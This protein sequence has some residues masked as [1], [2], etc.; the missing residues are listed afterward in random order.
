MSYSTGSATTVVNMMSAF[1]SFAVA[2]A[3]MTLSINRT[4]QVPSASVDPLDAYTV[5]CLSK[6]GQHWWF[7]YRS[8]KVFGFPC[9]SNAGADWAN[10]TNRPLNDSELTPIFE[11]FTSYHL[12]S[13]GSMVHAALEM[14]NGSWTHMNIFSL[15]KYGSFTGGHGLGVTNCLTD[16]S[17]GPDISGT[18]HNYMFGTPAMNDGGGLFMSR[19]Y[20]PYNGK[21]YANIGVPISHSSTDYNGALFAHHVNGVGDRIL[22]DCPN[23]FNGRTFGVRMEAF[24][25]DNAPG[26]SGLWLPLGYIPNIRAINIKDLNPKDVINTDWLAFPC[27]A[28]NAFLL[29]TYANSVNRGWAVRK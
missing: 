29:N 3:G 13:E 11:P 24:L 18:Y 16:S 6:T 14:S 17:F 23:A 7:R 9:S 15:T 26:G 20:L 28:K 8:N 19:M 12:H 21:Q 25:L 1:R 22:R 4:E 10:I 27:Q 5:I 2:N